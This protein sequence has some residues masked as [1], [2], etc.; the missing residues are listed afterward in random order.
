MRIGAI[1]K[2]RTRQVFFSKNYGVDPTDDNG[3]PLFGLRALRK[4]NANQSSVSENDSSSVRYE[5]DSRDTRVS[6][7]KK[8][9][10]GLKALQFENTY[11]VQESSSTVYQTTSEQKGGVNQL[12]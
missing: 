3:R 1:T 4:N 2:S 10:F 6:D 9:S 5:A 8:R 12:H 7:Q 11:T